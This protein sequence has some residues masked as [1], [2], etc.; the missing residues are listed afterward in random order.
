MEFNKQRNSDTQKQETKKPSGLGFFKKSPSSENKT[1]LN[2]LT[3]S[4]E[5]ALV[6]R[7]SIQRKM[8]EIFKVK[9]LVVILEGLNSTKR[10]S[11]QPDA[12]PE[13]ITV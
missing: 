7:A 8:T 9:I 4:L 10:S 3:N 12:V 2:V 5:I 6:S 13:M 11:T 1:G